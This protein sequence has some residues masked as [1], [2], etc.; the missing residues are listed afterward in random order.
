MSNSSRFRCLL[1]ANGYVVDGRAADMLG[2]LDLAV[3]AKYI[4]ADQCPGRELR[5]LDRSADLAVTHHFY[6]G[7]LFGCS[8]SFAIIYVYWTGGFAR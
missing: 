5:L 8:F 4:D 2:S 7:E 1:A 6:D 3:R